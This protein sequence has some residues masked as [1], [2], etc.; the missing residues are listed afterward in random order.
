MKFPVRSFIAG[1]SP[2]E[3][4]L[5]SD[6]V[7]DVSLFSSLS[8]GL[9]VEGSLGFAEFVGVIPESLVSVSLGGGRGDDALLFDLNS[10]EVGEFDVEVGDVGLEF[11]DD[12]VGG[13][14]L[15]VS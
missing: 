15:S 13:G 9:F 4:D 11:S 7:D 3:F 1:K 2:S 14:G 6:G 5:L 10:V 12:A 8:L